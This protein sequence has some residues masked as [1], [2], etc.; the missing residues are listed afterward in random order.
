MA[1]RVARTL[2]A[3]SALLLVASSAARAD[4]IIIS[5]DEIVTDTDLTEVLDR[6]VFVDVDAEV[7]V[8]ASAASQSSGAVNQVIDELVVSAEDA[9]VAAVIRGSAIEVSGVVLINQAPGGANNQV[10]GVSVSFSGDERSGPSFVH[11]DTVGE[12]RSTNSSKTEEGGV[13]TTRID[14]GAFAG[15]RGIVGL[16]QASNDGNNQANAVS[17][18]LGETS[19]L[20]IADIDAGQANVGGSVTNLSA[21]RSDFI[22]EGAFDDFRGIV[23][24]NQ[25]SGFGNN[26]ANFISI[27]VSLGLGFE[28]AP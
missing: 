5:D 22:G 17:V 16:N 24:V 19:N 9:D 18:S 25:S 10:N 7:L 26:Q 23:Q 12:Q 11:A 2:A 8:E 20:S 3:A 15:G 21:T 6:E 14:G 1:K 27:G 28:P 13:Y 4:V